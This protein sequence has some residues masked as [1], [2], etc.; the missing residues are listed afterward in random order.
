MSV[1]ENFGTQVSANTPPEKPRPLPPVP[2]LI[3]PSLSDSL[4]AGI[5]QFTWKRQSPRIR[6]EIS[7]TV[8][9]QK[10]F[11]AIVFGQD[12]TSLVIP[13]GEWYIR[14]AG[15]DESG[16]ESRSSIY[17]IIVR[18]A[19]I[20]FRFYILTMLMFV[21]SVGTTWW[22]WLIRKA[23]YYWIALMFFGLGTTSFFLLHW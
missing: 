22:T 15:I 1:P 10:P 8:T 23:R 20:P 21:L 5:M 17:R 16:L 11:H 18:K 3:T 7:E 19:N 2:E 4:F 12:S 14:L 6:F 13:E 9:F